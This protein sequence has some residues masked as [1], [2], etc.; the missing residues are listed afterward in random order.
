MAD[1]AVGAAGAVSA[2]NASLQEKEENDANGFLRRGVLGAGTASRRLDSGSCSS[3]SDCEVR[4]REYHIPPPPRCFTFF[5]NRIFSKTTV[6][7]TPKVASFN[8]SRRD[9]SLDRRNRLGKWGLSYSFRKIEL[10]QVVTAGVVVHYELTVPWMMTDV[11]SAVCRMEKL[12]T[13]FLTC[14]VY[15]SVRSMPTGWIVFGCRR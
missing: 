10:E 9:I 4:K 6:P 5:F 7:V 13:M 15:C 3:D 8:T 12:L 11:T 14:R 1:W 2:R